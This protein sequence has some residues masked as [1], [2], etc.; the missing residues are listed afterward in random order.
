MVRHCNPWHK[1]TNVDIVIKLK[2]IVCHW[3][4]SSCIPGKKETIV[5]CNLLNLE[6]SIGQGMSKYCMIAMSF[7]TQGTLEE[8]LFAQKFAAQTKK[9]LPSHSIHFVVSL[10]IDLFHVPSKGCNVRL[11]RFNL[12]SCCTSNSS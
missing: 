1:L 6:R 7:N 10:W 3:I 2:E 9:G 11:Q 8:T 12:L 5:I 4:C